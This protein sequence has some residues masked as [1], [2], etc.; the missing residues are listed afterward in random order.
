M[1]HITLLVD[2]LPLLQ[3]LLDVLGREG[4][5]V[6]LLHDL[7]VQQLLV[8]VTLGT[9][10]SS[11]A[12]FTH[13]LS[14]LIQLFHSG[15]HQC[16]ARLFQLIAQFAHFGGYACCGSIEYRQK[17]PEEVR[18]IADPPL[19]SLSAGLL[20]FQTLHTQQQPSVRIRKHLTQLSG[21][22]AALAPHIDEDGGLEIVVHTLREVNNT[23]ISKGKK[24]PK[25]QQ[26]HIFS[27]SLGHLDE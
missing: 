1:L 3:V 25:W 26:A 21:S 7:L 11:N 20:L 15:F 14:E 9:R 2:A 27:E 5:V 17:F 22:V 12:H 13:L 23:L 8:G 18:Q 10:G 24:I 16:D 19:H 6:E 4:S